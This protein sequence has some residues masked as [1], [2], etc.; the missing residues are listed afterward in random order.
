MVT[1]SGTERHER[2][3]L[4]LLIIGQEP[5]F[6]GKTKLQKLAFLIQIDSN[7]DLYDFKKHYYGPFSRE[8]DNDLVSHN[9]LVDIKVHPSIMSAERVYYEF[10]VTEE[11][12]KVKERLEKKLDKK[13]VNEAQKALKRYFDMPMDQLL[14]KAYECIDSADERLQ[15]LESNFNL[16]QNNVKHVLDKHHNR[17]SLFMLVILDYV[18]Q[19]LAQSK[20]IDAAQKA[21]ITRLAAELLETCE[22]AF[23]DIVPPVDSERLRPIF[24]NIADLWGSLIEYCERRGIGRNPFKTPLEE[25]LSEDEATRLQKALESIELKG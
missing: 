25:V 24:T 19:V 23:P 6:I 10:K 14:E 8:L 17:Q 1:M 4:P 12:H 9:E 15:G 2:L 5:H 7:L 20:S 11:G 18:Q 3:W 16:F 21:V 13:R 22:E